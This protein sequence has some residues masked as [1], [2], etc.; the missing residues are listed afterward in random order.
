MMSCPYCGGEIVVPQKEHYFPQSI[1]YNDWDFYACNE[2]NNIKRAH[3]VYPTHEIFKIIPAE[4][5][6]KKFK[7]LWARASFDKYLAI[8]PAKIMRRSFDERRWVGNS[9]MFTIEE[10]VFYGLDDL[11]EMYDYAAGMIELDANIQGLVMS[12]RCHRFLL[13]HTYKHEFPTPFKVMES[14]NVAEFAHYRLQGVLMVGSGRNNAWR[15]A[16]S[17]KTYFKDLLS[18]PSSK[19]MLL[20]NH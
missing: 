7:D 8:T 18:A 11:K 10:R 13:L 6:M 17:Y 1:V 19:E 20:A 3:I 15:S 14:M 4:F 16:S 12:S 5:S 2:C 9:N